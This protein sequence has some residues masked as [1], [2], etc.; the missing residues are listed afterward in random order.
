M[1]VNFYSTLRQIV[2][3]KTVEFDLPDGLTL[4]QLVAEVA[5]RYPALA[6]EILDQ[7]GNLHSHIHIFVNGREMSFLENGLDT[8]VTAENTISVFP[9]VGGG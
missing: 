6:H 2:G 9:A 3:T 4:R 5:L 7:N 8:I 1:K